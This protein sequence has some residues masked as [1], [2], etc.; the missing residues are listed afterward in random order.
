MSPMTKRQ[1]P[2]LRAPFLKYR[3]ELTSIPYYTQ[4]VERINKLVTA[5]YSKVCGHQN[6]DGFIG[7]A[8]Q[9]RKLMPKFENK[10]QL[11]V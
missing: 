11:Q 2:S 4:P 10:K 8:F 1:E 9:S 5:A 6:K 7:V 3:K